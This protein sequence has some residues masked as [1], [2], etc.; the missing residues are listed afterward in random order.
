MQNKLSS[1]PLSTPRVLCF[2]RFFDEIPGGIQRHVEY[3]FQGMQ[4]RA[5]M[6]NLVPART[7]KSAKL[8]LHGFPVYRKAAINID[9]S[10]AFSPV[11]PLEARRLHREQPFDVVHLHFPDPMSHLA[12]GTIPDSV[13]RV[14]SWHAD[15]VR[16]KTLLR[17]YRGLLLSAL[18]K[19]AAIIVATPA[20]IDSSPILNRQEFRAKTH[21]IPYGFDLQRFGE[22][23]DGEAIRCRYGG[24]IVFTLGRH[25]SYKGFD[26]LI[27]AM[28]RVCAETQLV[29]G[30]VGPLTADL[31]ALARAEHVADR[32]HFIGM[33]DEDDLPAYYQ[34]CTVFC[35][36]SVTSA[37]AFG[38]VQVEA[39]A[40]GRPVISTRLGTG[41]DYINRHGDTGLTV[42]PR[43]PHALAEAINLLTANREMAEAMGLRAR[44]WSQQEFGLDAMATRTLSVYRAAMAE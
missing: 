7:C 31:E 34:A 27:R 39:M 8:N 37:E 21:V 29:I 1:Q 13:P 15:V 28:S 44:A 14:I 18:R 35:L 43:D 23:A 22:P 36:P 24:P 17:A 9:S 5:D 30:G 12:S 32:I 40:A 6:V 42:P 3:L 26:V 20:H 10:V 11:L 19:A 33:V 41:V 25:V 16:Q 2:G 38:I 4:G